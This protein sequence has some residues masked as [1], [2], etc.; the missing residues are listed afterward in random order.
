MVGLTAEVMFKVE[1]IPG[2]GAAKAEHSGRKKWQHKSVRQENKL[3]FEFVSI[4]LFKR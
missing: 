4:H 1:S 2:L 3:D